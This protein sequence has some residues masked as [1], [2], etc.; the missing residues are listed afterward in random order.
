MKSD[1]GNIEAING[2]AGGFALIEVLI[3]VTISTS[4]NA[5]PPALPFMAS[6]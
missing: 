3:A 4:I 5:N 1:S 2:N 6:H